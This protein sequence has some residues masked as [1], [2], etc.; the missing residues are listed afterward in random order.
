MGSSP[1]DSQFGI[2]KRVK[3]KSNEI[4]TAKIGVQIKERP[5]KKQMNGSSK[6]LSNFHLSL[7]ENDLLRRKKLTK[8]QYI[9]DQIVVTPV[10]M[11]EMLVLQHEFCGQFYYEK[12]YQRTHERFYW[13]EMSRDVE[14]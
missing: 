1:E 11:E 13:P 4:R 6:S 3:V 10:F 5:E 8:E 9:V 12:T 2:P 14:Y 7:I